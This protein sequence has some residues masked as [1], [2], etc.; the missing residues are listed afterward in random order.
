MSPVYSFFFSHHFLIS[1]QLP[2]PLLYRLV[3]HLL[4]YIL[5]RSALFILGIFWISVEQ[6]TRKRGLAHEIYGG[7]IL[8]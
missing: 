3:E 6:V 2:I 7:P 1:P 5:G 8:S 4:T